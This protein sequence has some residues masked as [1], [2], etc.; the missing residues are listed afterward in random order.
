MLRVSVHAGPPKTVSRFNRTD[1]LDIGY[2][3]LGPPA[4]Y[5]IVLF[6]SGQGV[7]SPVEVAKYPRWS[8][9]IWDLTARAIARSLSAP[10]AAPDTLPPVIGPESDDDLPAF[11]DC[12]TAVINHF[13]SEGPGGRRIGEAVVRRV[14]GARSRYTAQVAEDSRTTRHSGPFEYAPAQLSPAELLLHGVLA[15]LSGSVAA[16]PPRPELQLPHA[17]T[18]G[19]ESYVRI[20]AIHEPARTGFARWLRGHSI[21][22]VAHASAPEGLATERDFI[23]FLTHAV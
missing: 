17:I 6:E 21:D 12:I 8:G 10:A 18:L 1:W 3:R 13:P 20:H 22:T 19:G 4:D 14:S 11:A 15:A 23:E 5:K 16:L 2:E 7:R 9:S